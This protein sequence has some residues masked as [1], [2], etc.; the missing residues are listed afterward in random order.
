M[1]DGHVQYDD[2]YPTDDETQTYKL[3][4]RGVFCC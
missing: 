1:L 3:V 4:N 2:L